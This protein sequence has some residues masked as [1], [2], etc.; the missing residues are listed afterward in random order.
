MTKVLKIYKE[1]FITNSYINQIKIK[2][3]FQHH[4]QLKITKSL[5]FTANY[6][7]QTIIVYQTLVGLTND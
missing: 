5:Y 2:S 1:M 7:N 4:L 6:A 3:L